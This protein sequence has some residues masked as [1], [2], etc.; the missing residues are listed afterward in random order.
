VGYRLP[1]NMSIVTPPSSC[2]NC[3]KRLT[4][5]ELIPIISYI[6]QGG[7]CRH[8]HEHI[9]IYYPIFEFL[10]GVLF[11]ISYLIFGMKEELMIA[12][13]FSSTLLI[14]MISDIRYMVIPDEL[15][16]FSGM[17]LFLAKLILYHNIIDL[18][19][20]SVIP[21]IILYLIKAFGDIL[22]K[23]ESLG[24]GDIK[25]MIIFGIVLVWKL[26]ILSIFLGAFLALPISLMILKFKKTNIIPFGP[27]LSLAALIIYFSQID[28]S[29]IL[30]ILI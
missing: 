4:F 20:D 16:V 14:V 2:P 13:I 28:I 17:I 6:I 12:L 22:F 8:C 23:K 10:T 3:G 30:N 29:N 9:S 26:A 21:V 18:V 24:G 19:L 1:K 15:L 7:K 5:I 11:V 27:F 25:L